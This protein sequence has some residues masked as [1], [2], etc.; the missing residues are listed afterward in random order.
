MD[1]GL[2][3]LS[4]MSRGMAN[5]R[6]SSLAAQSSGGCSRSLRSPKE[7]S[8]T[9]EEEESLQTSLETQ[10]QHQ[11]PENLVIK[12]DGHESTGTE[13][14]L[15]CEETKMDEVAHCPRHADHFAPPKSNSKAQT[16]GMIPTTIDEV[17]FEDGVR[18]AEVLASTSIVSNQGMHRCDSSG[19]SGSEQWELVSERSKAS[20]PFTA[21][22]ASGNI[23]VSRSGSV[24]SINSF[25]SSSN[26]LSF[27]LSHPVALKRSTSNSTLDSN[28]GLHTIAATGISGVDYVEHVVLPSDTLQGLCLSYK[29]SATRLRQANQFSGSTLLLAPKKLIVPLSYNA[30][31]SGQIRM[32][33]RESREFKLYAF[34]AEFPEMKNVDAKEYLD[35]ADWDLNEAIHLAHDDKDW[36]KEEAKDN[37]EENDDLARESKSGVIKITLNVRGRKFTASGA[38]ISIREDDDSERVEAVCE[39]AVPAVKPKTVRAEDIYKATQSHDGFGVELQDLASSSAN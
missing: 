3:F 25:G 8:P 15:P 23:L 19:T 33:D 35:K 32:Q 6:E 1:G 13:V 21:A 11:L 30:L 24:R 38:G 7:C 16:G 29:I 17:S 28:D 20:S 22:N 12:D 18:L 14:S 4:L 31:K 34:L 27:S 26:A 2:K 39:T 5:Q 37:T 36:E 9:L 10:Q